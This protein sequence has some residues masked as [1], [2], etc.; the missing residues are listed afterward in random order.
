MKMFAIQA[1]VISIKEFIPEKICISDDTV[2][3]IGHDIVNVIQPEKHTQHIGC[4]LT[5]LKMEKLFM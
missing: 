4:N 2:A 1:S 5:L 3:V